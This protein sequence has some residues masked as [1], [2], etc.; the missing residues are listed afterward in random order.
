MALFGS[1][2][3]RNRATIGR[4]PGQRLSGR[5]HDPAPC[6]RGRRRRLGGL[7]GPRRVPVAELVTGPGR[8]VVQ[9]RRVDRHDRGP[10]PTGEEGFRKFGTRQADAISI[11]SLAW[12]WRRDED[13]T[14]ARRRPGLRGCGAHRGA[15][16][17]GRVRARRVTDLTRRW[18]LGPWRRSSRTYR[19]STTSAA[20]AQVPPRDVGVLLREEFGL[21]QRPVSGRTMVRT[22]SRRSA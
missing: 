17:A 18:S 20:S 22:T 5:R 1:V 4:E 21:R 12:R 3:I 16:E 6:G 11:V 15:S 13:G 8:T 10:L 19:R 2:R 7:D 14:A 9:R